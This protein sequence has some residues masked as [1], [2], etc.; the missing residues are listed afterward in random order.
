MPK[1]SVAVIA[2]DEERDLPRC[3]S[4]VRFADEIVLVDSG[5][6]DR[7]RELAPAPGARVIDQPWL[8]YGR[9]KAFA[10]AQT[11]GDWV[12]NLDADEAL[13]P[14]LS[15]EIP[16]AIAREGVDGYRLRF[17]S[18][19]FG[20][21]LR[22]GGARGETHLR[23][24]RKS[25]GRYDERAIHEGVTVAGRVETL[26]GFIDHVP[27]ATVSEYLAKLE[28]YTSLAAEERHAAGR[29][30]SKLSAARLPWGFFRRYVLWLGA[31]DGYAG[32]AAASL[33]AL[34]DFLKEA[35]LQDLER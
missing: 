27:Y 35:K 13:S 17:R 29:R 34:S 7:T 21:R 26:V 8:G 16:A 6:R 1:L 14:E 32:F 25:A 11:R 10:V 22:F 3:L 24:F 28:R 18:E 23:L 31:L 4:S 33:G 20:R 5:S 19:L 12:L 9:Q 15:E 2:Q 30:F